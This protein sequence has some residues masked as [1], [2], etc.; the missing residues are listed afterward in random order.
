MPVAT[1]GSGLMALSP[2]SGAIGRHMHACGL[3]RRHHGKFIEPRF[4]QQFATTG[5][6]EIQQPD[7]KL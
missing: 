4:G 2:D 7:K 5:F 1:C 6:R 3:E